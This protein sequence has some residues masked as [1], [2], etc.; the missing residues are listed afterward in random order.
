[1]LYFITSPADNAPHEITEGMRSAITAMEGENIEC[2]DSIDEILSNVRTNT[3]PKIQSQLEATPPP[4]LLLPTP[5]PTLVRPHTQAPSSVQEGS[6]SGNTSAG[7]GEIDNISGLLDLT[8]KKKTKKNLAPKAKDISAKIGQSNVIAEGVKRQPIPSTRHDAFAT[9]LKSVEQGS[10]EGFHN[11]FL[12]LSPYKCR[13]SQPISSRICYCDQWNKTTHL[14]FRSSTAVNLDMIISKSLVMA[15]L[16][17]GN[18]PPPPRKIRG[19][20]KERPTGKQ[21][22]ELNEI[23]AVKRLNQSSIQFVFFFNYTKDYSYLA[24]RFQDDVRQFHDFEFKQNKRWANIIKLKGKIGHQ[25]LMLSKQ[26]F[27]CKRHFLLHRK[28]NSLLSDIR[29]RLNHE[30][31][32]CYIIYTV[33]AVNQSWYWFNI[34]SYETYIFC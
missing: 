14:S 6:T 1:M 32:A 11:S 4:D 30:F 15:D 17:M 22:D 10:I 26:W 33:Q 12:A 9:Q 34:V 20:S 31:T 27:H 23:W 21:Q 13:L 2:S 5:D 25:A 19:M 28:A 7:A 18:E 8:I 29:S 24:K 3:Q 16:N